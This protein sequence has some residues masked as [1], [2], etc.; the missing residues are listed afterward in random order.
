MGCHIHGH[1][2]VHCSQEFIQK[3]WRKKYI[4]SN[5]GEDFGQEGEPLKESPTYKFGMGFGPTSSDD[6]KFDELAKGG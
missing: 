4:V 5:F 1:V 3:V 6:D 2:V